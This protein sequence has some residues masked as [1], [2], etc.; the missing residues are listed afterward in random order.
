VESKGTGT[1][2]AALAPFLAVPPFDDVHDA[3]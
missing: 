3:W 1:G 2:D